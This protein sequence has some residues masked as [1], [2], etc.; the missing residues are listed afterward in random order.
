MCIRYWCTCTPRLPLPP[1]LPTFH[2]SP[3]PPL[4]S[5]LISISPGCAMGREADLHTTWYG[6]GAPPRV[7][8]RKQ[9]VKDKQRRENAYVFLFMD[10]WT[11]VTKLEES[12]PVCDR[13][14]VVAKACWREWPC[15]SRCVRELV[16]DQCVHQQSP[17]GS[18]A[19]LAKKRVVA[20]HKRFLAKEFT[21]T[22]SLQM[23]IANIG[24]PGV[25]VVSAMCHSLLLHAMKHSMQLI[26]SCAV[27]LTIVLLCLRCCRMGNRRQGTVS[28][29]SSWDGGSCWEVI[30]FS[31]SC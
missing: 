20:R 13:C 22:Q 18:D 19:D 15:C 1:R 21:Y 3:H 11:D 26:S 6:K 31:R 2:N 8:A 12:A 5:L 29:R 7:E 28:W 25:F 14:R 17:D 9:D 10:R 24:V 27:W 23:S 16:G 4:S 30:N